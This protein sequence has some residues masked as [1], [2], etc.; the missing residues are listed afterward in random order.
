MNSTDEQI[1]TI[2]AQY[3]V[4]ADGS[5][6]RVEGQAFIHH[7]ALERIAAQAKIT[8]ESPTVLRS[9][10][11]EAV[12]LV[13]GRMGERVEWSIG[14]AIVGVNYD[15]PGSEPAYVYAMAE[16]RAKDRVILKLIQLHDVVSSEEPQ[17][18]ESR[19][20]GSNENTPAVEGGMEPSIVPE[21]E[22]RLDECVT[23]EAV[24]ALMRD[25]ETQQSLAVLPQGLVEQIREYAKARM[26][27]LGWRPKRAV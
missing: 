6:W 4:P 22:R 21:L 14:E 17:V 26:V 23:V 1:A 15:P 18:L 13:L 7:R 3:G 12:L 25:S 20:R 10:R 27:A 5:V 8:F 9:E 2:L 11:D 16:K 19:P 24:V